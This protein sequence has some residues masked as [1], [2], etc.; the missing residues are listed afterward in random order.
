MVI[1]DA[2]PEKSVDESEDASS[3]KKNDDDGNSSQNDDV[4]KKNRR[5]RKLLLSHQE[6][7]LGHPKCHQ[8]YSLHQNLQYLV[9]MSLL[10]QR[11]HSQE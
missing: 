7:K 4:E 5:K 3:L 9:M 11:N 6:G 8:V 10:H 1:D 2:I